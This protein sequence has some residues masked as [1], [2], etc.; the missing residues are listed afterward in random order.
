METI[1]SL[2]LNHSPSSLASVHI[3][4]EGH[5][6][7]PDDFVAP[8]NVPEFLERFPGMIPDYVLRR[9]AQATD[10]ER[11]ELVTLLEQYLRSPSALS[12][13]PD[14]IAMFALLP[15]SAATDFFSF[16]LISLNG[17]RLI[18]LPSS[19]DVES[20]LSFQRRPSHCT[21]HPAD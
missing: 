3:L 11:S 20:Q 6:I 9:T 19:L 18:P 4:A 2:T 7:G 15:A 8:R 12:D 1:L 17:S 21:H 10:A 16:V 5:T 14:R 13:H